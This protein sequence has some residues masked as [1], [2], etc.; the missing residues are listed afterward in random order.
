M[1]IPVKAGMVKKSDIKKVLAN[2]GLGREQDAKLKRMAEKAE[3]L[4][5]DAEAYNDWLEK[6]DLKEILTKQGKT[7]QGRVISAVDQVKKTV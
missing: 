7:L 2:D 1:G 4:Q 6:N 5:K 3:S